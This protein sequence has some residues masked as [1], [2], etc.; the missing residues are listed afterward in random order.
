[1]ITS[2]EILGTEELLLQRNP[3]AAA[4][5]QAIVARGREAVIALNERFNDPSD[6]TAMKRLDTELEAI[7]ERSVSEYVRQA[8]GLFSAEDVE[9]WT[10]KVTRVPGS[11]VG[12]AAAVGVPGALLLM[13]SVEEAE[14]EENSTFVSLDDTLANIAGYCQC[15][16]ATSRIVPRQLCRLCSGGVLIAWRT[17]EDQV[18]ATAPKVRSELHAVFEELLDE[19]A[20]IH[21]ATGDAS[22]ETPARRRAGNAGITRVNETYAEDIAMLDVTRWREL[23]DLNQLSQITAVT[24]HA[25]HWSQWGLGSARL[26]MLA[27]QSDPEIQARMRRIAGSRPA[28]KPSLFE[29]LFSRR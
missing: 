14:S 20:T 13:E 27:M 1:M 8:S 10:A 9:L 12:R 11:Y 19:L 16:Y 5:H 23:S 4:V 2:I 26:A 29:R 22:A 3:R 15:G 7:V 6:D 21:L 24:A 17:E 25:K 18:I 28:P